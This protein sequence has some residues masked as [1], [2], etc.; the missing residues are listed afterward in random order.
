M[1]YVYENTEVEAGN[2]CGIIFPEKSCQPSHP[3]KLEWAITPSSVPKPDISEP[4]QPP[5][6]CHLTWVIP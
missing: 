1:R 5:V 3:E 4:S 2:I 6:I